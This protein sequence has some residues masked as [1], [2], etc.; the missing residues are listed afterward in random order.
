MGS[1]I[2]E[3]MLTQFLA[4]SETTNAKARK[5]AIEQTVELNNLIPPTVSYESRGNLV[6]IGP[7]SIIVD[8]AEQFS[9]LNS[10]TL[11]STESDTQDK[12]NRQNRLSR[13]R[14]HH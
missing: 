6:I 14:G 10:I 12:K 5:F 2:G 4:Q 7:T 8:V 1:R 13:K 3:A 9:E 11:V